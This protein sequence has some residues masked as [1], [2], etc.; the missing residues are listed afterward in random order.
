MVFKEVPSS[1]AHHQ[2]HLRTFLV[3]N[4]VLNK[5]LS[6]SFFVLIMYFFRHGVF[7]AGFGFPLPNISTNIPVKNNQV[8]QLKTQKINET[9]KR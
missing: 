8:H 5:K 1:K 2:T 3:Q 9:A 7:K 4:S 6:N